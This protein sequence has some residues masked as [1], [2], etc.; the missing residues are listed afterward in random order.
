VT[1]EVAVKFGSDLRG[2][3]SGF[4]NCIKVADVCAGFLHVHIRK[5]ALVTGIPRHAFVA[6]SVILEP[7]PVASVLKSDAWPKIFDS[8]IQRVTV[9]VVDL[10]RK[11]S[12]VV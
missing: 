11:K 2:G 4:L 10:V 5:P 3:L 1:D 9:Y 12:V 6:R 7:S 8:V